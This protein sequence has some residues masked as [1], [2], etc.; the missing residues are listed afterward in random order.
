MKIESTPI[1]AADAL[2]QARKDKL[3]AIRNGHKGDL[4]NLLDRAIALLGHAAS[5]VAKREPDPVN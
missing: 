5:E 3:Q 4:L 1:E 2:I